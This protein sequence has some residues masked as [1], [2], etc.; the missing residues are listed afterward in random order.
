MQFSSHLML[1]Q[2]V[3]YYYYKLNCGALSWTKENVWSD[4][5]V[6]IILGKL[7]HHCTHMNMLPK[8][9]LSMESGKGIKILKTELL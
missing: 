8:D 9:K 1:Q 5:K 7:S 3:L 4:A 2:R 6:T